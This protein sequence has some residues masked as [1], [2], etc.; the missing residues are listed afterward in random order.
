MTSIAVTGLLPWLHSIQ[1]SSRIVENV[2]EKV[3]N[4]IGGMKMALNVDEQNEVRC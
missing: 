3:F 2:V 1:G 4:G